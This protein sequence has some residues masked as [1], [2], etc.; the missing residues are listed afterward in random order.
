MPTLGEFIARANHYGY[1]RHTIHIPELGAKLVYLRRG[2]GDS[3]K[4]VELPFGP[5][6]A[7][8]AREVVLSLC[9][10]AGIPAEDFGLSEE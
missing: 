9:A 3:A 1:T 6:H 8:L 4:L 10:T 5:Q 2:K 7:R